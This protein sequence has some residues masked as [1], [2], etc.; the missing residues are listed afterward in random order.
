[1]PN[2]PYV[3]LAAAPGQ[4]P[5]AAHSKNADTVRAALIQAQYADAELDT[6]ERRLSWSSVAA[7]RRRLA[8]AMKLLAEASK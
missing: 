4:P 5:K 2:P 7:A 3:P 6:A 1:M 8:D